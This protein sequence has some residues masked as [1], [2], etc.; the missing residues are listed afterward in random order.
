[1]YDLGSKGEREVWLENII[2]PYCEYKNEMGIGYLTVK[3]TQRI[4]DEPP[5]E[6]VIEQC[7]GCLKAFEIRQEIVKIETPDYKAT[8]VKYNTQT[9]TH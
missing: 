9:I 8:T 1:M 3:F 5:V 6:Y 2:C 4:E 7:D